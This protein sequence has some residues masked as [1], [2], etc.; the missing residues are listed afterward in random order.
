MKAVMLMKIQ[1][2]TDD[3]DEMD[4][5]EMNVAAAGGRIGDS[6]QRSNQ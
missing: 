5:D 3:D 1:R 6:G 2:E 4:D